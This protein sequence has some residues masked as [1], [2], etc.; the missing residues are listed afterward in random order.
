M[1][2]SPKSPQRQPGALNNDKRKT[3]LV[4]MGTRPEA[5]KLAPVVWAVR[6]YPKVFKVKICS[7]GQHRHMLDQALSEFNLKPDID[8]S[9]M[10]PLQS[11]ADLN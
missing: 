1:L 4:F 2:P 3:I 5:I 6:K 8:F 10:R 11:L 7:T 9:V